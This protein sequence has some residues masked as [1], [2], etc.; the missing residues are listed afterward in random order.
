MAHLTNKTTRAEATP[1]EWLGVGRAVGEL[2]NKWSERSDLVGY[3]GENAGHGAP[4][5]YNPSLAEIEVDTRIAF[6]AGVTPTMV[7]DMTQR[8]QQYEFPK[9]TGAIMHEAFHAKFSKWDIPAAQKALAKDE[10][11]ALMWL[12]ES[13]IEAHGVLAMPKA[14]PF[15]KACALEIVVGEAKETFEN[16]SNTM[17]C[18]FFVAT[19]HARIDAGVL[20]YEDV[21]QLVDNVN[22][23]LGLE[24]VEKLRAIARKFQA[25]R[26]HAVAD[27]MLYD[28]A[29]EWAEI[30][31]E[32]A[33]E[34]G[35]APSEGEGA[36]GEGAEGA[37]G[38]GEGSGAS[39]GGGEGGSSSATSDFI[40]E[41]M[42][43]LED[44]RDASAVGSFDELA[45]WEEQEAWEEQAK[46][47]QA[48]QKER[49]QHKEVASSTFNKGTGEVT[50]RSASYVMEK[51]PPKPEERVAAVTVARMLEKAKYRERSETEVASVT[52]P[53]R[54]RTRA[55]VQGRA[56]KE[57]GVMTQVEPWRK[58]VR[59]QTDDPTLTVGVMV[60]ISG[61]MGG[62]MQPM[63]TTAWVMSE[64]VK[65]VQ[66][67][68]AM[69]YFGT[70]VF[71]TLKA[72]QHLSEVT[73]WAA[74]DGTEK[75]D[76]AFKAL[77]GSLNL[78]HGTGARLLVVVSDG[79]YTDGEATAARKWVTR[80][81]ESG[82]GVLWL[83]FDNGYYAQRYGSVAKGAFQMVEG[84]L[85]PQET[86]K[87][88]GTAAAKALASVGAQR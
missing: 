76:H 87:A 52:P 18:A 58:T 78:L 47:K 50:G 32:A 72:G 49:K 46:E 48:T 35:D 29:R 59:K 57:R 65:R 75:F 9:A 22:E 24:V 40:E 86:A 81:A 83:P 62:A 55:L 36:E 44:A 45:D 85:D 13:R 7:G 15:L 51:R 30:V 70:D 71:A 23:Y 21:E 67:K 61:S 31:R 14:R 16:H 54:L 2:A 56:L 26:M 4:A 19:V 79:C 66:G 34:N 6:G 17:S 1:P 3:V 73:T 88:I 82:V 80:C 5:C 43:A 41:M 77:D 12:E 28:L 64:A 63:A 68:T 38:E 74:T 84:S 20:D 25:H 10:F 60:D 11:T 39:E 42:E 27:P 69:V 8:S 53:G 37:E 33:V